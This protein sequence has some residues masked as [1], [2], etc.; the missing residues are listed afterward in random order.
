M[1]GA[2]SF[3]STSAALL[4]QLDNFVNGPDLELNGE[5]YSSQRTTYLLLY[6]SSSIVLF[7]L[8]SQELKDCITGGSCES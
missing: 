8:F 5:G 2:S 1:G 6:L 3:D 7:L 4:V